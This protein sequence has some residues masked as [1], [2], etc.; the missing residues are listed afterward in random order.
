M[1]KHWSN[2]HRR[3]FLYEPR[4]QWITDSDHNRVLDIRGW[5]FL[6]GSGKVGMSLEEG[7]E[8]QDAIGEHVT[9]LLNKH[10][11]EGDDRGKSS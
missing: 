6:T 11:G 10:W 2:I 1:A 3:P 8:A 5:G 7:A 9:E 4:G